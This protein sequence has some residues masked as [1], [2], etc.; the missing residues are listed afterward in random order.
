MPIKTL[1]TA[2]KIKGMLS[3]LKSYNL[4]NRSLGIKNKKRSLLKNKQYLQNN[5]ANPSCSMACYAIKKP[6]WL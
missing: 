1:G 6:D 4:Q 5:E 3:N 2:I